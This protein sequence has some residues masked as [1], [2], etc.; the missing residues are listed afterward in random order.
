MVLVGSKLV[1]LLRVHQGL[2]VLEALLVNLDLGDPAAA[3]GV[4][5]RDLVEVAR[6]LLEHEVDL[7]DLAAHGGVDV[8]GTLDRLDGTDSVALV[9]GPALL[10]ELDVDEV[11]EGLGGVLADADDAGLLVGGEVNPFVLLGVFPDLV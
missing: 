3:V 2:K 11:T 8:G 5:L 10:W 9:D 7:G 1:V 6:L 4:I